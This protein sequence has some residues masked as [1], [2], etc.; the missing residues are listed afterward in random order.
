MI[1]SC[2]RSIIVSAAEVTGQDWQVAG[3]GKKREIGREYRKQD[4]EWR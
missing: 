1:I 2:W 3:P 4:Q